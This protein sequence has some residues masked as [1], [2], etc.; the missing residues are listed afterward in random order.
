[1][2]LEAQASGLPAL[3]ST[4]GGPRE[5]VEH[6]SSGLVL[7]TMDPAAWAGAIAGLLDNSERRNRMSESAVRRMNRYSLRKTFDQFW[8]R[9]LRAVHGAEGDEATTTR[10]AGAKPVAARV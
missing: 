8:E 2:V 3:V 6:E 9:H 5:L 1:V 7:S 4:L 10:A